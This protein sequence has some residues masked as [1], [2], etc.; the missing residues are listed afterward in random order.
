LDRTLW[1]GHILSKRHF[2][3]SIITPEYHAIDPYG[4]DCAGK[5]YYKN[6]LQIMMNHNATTDNESAGSQAFVSVKNILPV[7]WL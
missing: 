6:D 4:F 5:E 3:N 2:C 1:G 7:S